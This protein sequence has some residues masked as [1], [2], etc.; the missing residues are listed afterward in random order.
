MPRQTKR[1]EDATLSGVSAALCFFTYA[2]RIHA[3]K[4]TFLSQNFFFRLPTRLFCLKKFF[5]GSQ[6][7]FFAIIFCFQGFK[8]TFY[9]K[10]FVFEPT[11]RLFYLR[12]TDS[13]FQLD[14]F[15]CAERIQPSKSTFLP[16]P[17]GF[18]LPTQLF[19]LYKAVWRIPINPRSAKAPTLFRIDLIDEHGLLVVQVVGNLNPIPV[20]AFLPITARRNEC[21]FERYSLL[22]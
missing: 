17:N 7:D 6:L 11:S 1:S 19:Y 16:E 20:I 5:S 15:C 14:F 4:S 9:P 12:R 8:S 2:E 21:P 13:V 22:V 18:R 10:Y 3:S